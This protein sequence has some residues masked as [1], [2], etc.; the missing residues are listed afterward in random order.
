[1]TLNITGSS[2]PYNFGPFHV[3]EFVRLEHYKRGSRPWLMV[4]FRARWERKRTE[5]LSLLFHGKIFSLLNDS[6]R[7]NKMKSKNLGESKF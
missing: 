2:K 7:Q 1:V 6:R 5:Y 4:G 3:V